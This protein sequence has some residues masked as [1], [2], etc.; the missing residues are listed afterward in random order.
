MPL[1]QD[2]QLAL[3]RREAIPA[4]GEGGV[5]KRDADGGLGF[6]SLPDQ[7]I[8]EGV[9]N[10]NG[11][12]F[13]YAGRL[14]VQRGAT[15]ALWMNTD[16]LS[17]W[18]QLG[19]T[20]GALITNSYYEFIDDG[21]TTGK[22][23]T[24]GDVANLWMT[25]GLSGF[26]QGSDVTLASGVVTI[27][28]TG[29]YSIAATWEPKAD[30]AADAYDYA[31]GRFKLNRINEPGSPVHDQM[32]LDSIQF[33]AVNKADNKHIASFSAGVTAFMYAADTVTC[34]SRFESS[35]TAGSNW[36]INT[37]SMY[38]ERLA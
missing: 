29:V 19:S 17:T 16:G 28:T 33:P 32:F 37:A 5:L 22:L 10:P 4:G 27:A 26:N 21:T 31:R 9:A 25:T 18:A 23:E 34:D 24:A 15:P 3:M 35:T 30:T 8:L 1:S 2:I 13:A 20:S 11:V 14:Y 38:I 12:I 36:S 7:Q 6:V